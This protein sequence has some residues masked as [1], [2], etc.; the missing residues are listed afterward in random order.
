MNLDEYISKRS[1]TELLVDFENFK[2]Q[3]QIEV[4]KYINK[5]NL[6]DLKSYLFSF[7]KISKI[8]E[9]DFYPFKD[10]LLMRCS[11]CNLKKIVEEHQNY[12]NWAKKNKVNS[13]KI[14]NLLYDF[15]NFLTKPI[16]SETIDFAISNIIEETELKCQKIVD[17]LKNSNYKKIIIKPLFSQNNYVSEKFLVK[18][19]QNE[20]VVDENCETECSLTEN[21][22]DLNFLNKSNKKKFE[23][24]QI[25]KP[26]SFYETVI[27]IQKQIS[28]GK[29]ILYSEF[30]S[31]S[32]DENDD[33]YEIVLQKKPCQPN[34]IKWIKKI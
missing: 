34:T 6:N 26:K 21:C 24:I 17:F 8:L 16:D 12:K 19:D 18:C 4:S 3:L 22:E 25:Q 33:F 1:Q 28:L 9:E 32:K 31:S 30:F 14:E 27:K 23:R 11:T 29:I 10:R 5:N 13:Q 15:V 2:D 20:F 7:N